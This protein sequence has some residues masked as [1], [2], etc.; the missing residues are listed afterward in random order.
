MDRNL[1][2]WRG[3]HCTPLP[4]TVCGVPRVSLWGVP[5]TPLSLRTLLPWGLVAQIQKR[6]FL[7]RTYA[8]GFD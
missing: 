4:F 7:S 6:I 1:F 8:M 3:I 5:H 2:H